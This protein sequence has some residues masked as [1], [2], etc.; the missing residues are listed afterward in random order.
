MKDPKDFE[1]RYLAEVPL[2]S[3]PKTPWQWMSWIVAEVF[4]G[5]LCLALGSWILGYCGSMVLL[6]NAS[7]SWP[8]VPGQVLESE[9]DWKKQTGD[10]RI[11]YR[12]EVS[13]RSY[14]SQQVSFDVFMTPG[15]RGKP[16]T[17]WLRYPP[18]KLVSVYYNPQRPEQ[19]IL[20]PGDYGQ[21][22][23]PALGG[24]GAVA[25]GFVLLG[26]SA[27]RLVHGLN[28]LPSDREPML[29]MVLAGALPFVM[30]YLILSV[31]PFDSEIE[32]DLLRDLGE[33]PLGLP[34]ALFFETLVN[35]FFLPLTWFAYHAARVVRQSGR[36]GWGL[37]VAYLLRIGF[38][39]PELRRSQ[40]I[41]MGCVF[42][43]TLIPL[44]GII[45]LIWLRH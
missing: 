13:G 8:Q 43:L 6:A 37:D 2:V 11:R 21:F 15:G 41:A 22:A 42:Y 16:R 40:R 7:G 24:F 27:Y 5:L 1:E 29:R 3:L 9:Y 38:L 20:E 18:K 39:H 36:D 12:Y 44:A 33:R 31:A 4:P 19:A 10:V 28:S 17:V 23:F 30:I 34:M 25:F 32:E 14:V 45:V 26:M 35:L